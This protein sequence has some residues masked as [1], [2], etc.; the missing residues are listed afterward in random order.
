MDLSATILQASK[1]MS[2]WRFIGLDV[3]R[4]LHAARGVQSYTSGD[5]LS[6]ASATS[7]DDADTCMEP[8]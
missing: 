2:R 6:A 4:S 8:T 5:V 3:L 1:R 7:K